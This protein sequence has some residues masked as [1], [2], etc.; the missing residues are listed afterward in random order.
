MPMKKRKTKKVSFT[1]T[2]P[3][4]RRFRKT[5]D[6]IVFPLVQHL[7]ELGFSQVTADD[8]RLWIRE[9]H[10]RCIENLFVQ[11]WIRNEQRKGITFTQ[12]GG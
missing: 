9:P 5:W 12:T 2:P 7:Q 1:N 4:P 10:T 8:V 3:N 11:E 6:E